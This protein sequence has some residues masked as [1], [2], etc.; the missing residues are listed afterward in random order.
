MKMW[1]NYVTSTEVLVI[2]EM[3]TRR[4]FFALIT[5]F[6]QMRVLFFLLHL[7]LSA[8]AL[9]MIT[10]CMVKIDGC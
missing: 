1:Q 10:C 7:K 4:L 9:W 2:I 8:N 6:L 5:V 3:V